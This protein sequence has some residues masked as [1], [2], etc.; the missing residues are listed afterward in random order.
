M[1]VQKRGTVLGGLV[2]ALVTLSACTGRPESPDAWGG[3]GGGGGGG[4]RV[5][6]SAGPGRRGPPAAAGG[7]Q[8]TAGSESPSTVPEVSAGDLA[9][10]LS[11]AEDAP[12]VGT[13][14][15]DVPVGGG[16]TRSVVADALSVD[17]YPDRTLVRFTLASGDGQEI[18][19]EAYS[20]AGAD[21]NLGYVEGLA[22]VDP[23]SEQRLS[24]Y[25]E[26]DREK[27][28]S[29][30]QTCSAKPKSLGAEKF[31]QTCVLPPLDPATAT[32]TLEIPD[33]PAIEN[34]PVT[35]HEE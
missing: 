29:A 2:V 19:L 33:L 9:L 28:E 20:L 14:T 31:P 15:G 25:R 30:F 23:G 34:V 11:A 7:P 16:A 24:S 3:R 32:V 35:R 8:Q 13:A 12:A 22:V 26:A 18:R 4:A 21:W 10:A 5:R 17:A 6:V 27:G 1:N